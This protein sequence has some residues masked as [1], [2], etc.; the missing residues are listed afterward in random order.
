LLVGQNKRKGRTGFRPAVTF[1]AGSRVDRNAGLRWMAGRKASL[2]IAADLPCGPR[3]VLRQSKRPDVPPACLSIPGERPIRA[4]LP[5]K[6]WQLTLSSH[7]GSATASAARQL[8][9]RAYRRSASRP[10]RSRHGLPERLSLNGRGSSDDTS[11]R[12]RL[13]ISDITKGTSS[14]RMK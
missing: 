7:A 5:R 13:L 6:W 12:I 3:A 2:R 1:V 9:R 14:L 4:Q 8:C 10:L 11:L